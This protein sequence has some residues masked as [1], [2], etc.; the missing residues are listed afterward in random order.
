[1]TLKKIKNGRRTKKKIKKMED[2]LKKKKNEFPR[3]QRKYD[4]S[5]FQFSKKAG[6]ISETFLMQTGKAHIDLQHLFYF[7]SW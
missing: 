2:D 5:M 1:M 7:Y 6:D 3:Q 4:D